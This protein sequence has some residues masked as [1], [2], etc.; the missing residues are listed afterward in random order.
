MTCA[1]GERRVIMMRRVFA[2]AWQAFKLNYA[3]L[4]G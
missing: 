2:D 4:S 1:G 3:S